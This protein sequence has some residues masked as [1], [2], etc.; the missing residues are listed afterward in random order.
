IIEVGVIVVGIMS[1]GVELSMGEEDLL[2]LKVPAVKSSSYKGP[3][4]RSNSCCDGAVES[5]EGETVCS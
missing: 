1:F 2:T 4:R 5:A 3:D